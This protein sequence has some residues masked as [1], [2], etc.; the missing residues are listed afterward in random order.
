MKTSEYKKFIELYFEKNGIEIGNPAMREFLRPSYL[1]YSELKRMGK[2]RVENNLKVVLDDVK[3]GF[4]KRAKK[5]KGHVR[6]VRDIDVK[7]VLNRYFCGL[8]PFCR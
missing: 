5:S 6:I 1:N 3:D 7:P 2:N 4:E 8:P